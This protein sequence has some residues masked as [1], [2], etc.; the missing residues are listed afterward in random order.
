MP[1]CGDLWMWMRVL[2]RVEL[3]RGIGRGGP[4]RGKNLLWD[5]LAAGLGCLDTCIL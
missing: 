4:G 5:A 1:V 2:Q 3:P